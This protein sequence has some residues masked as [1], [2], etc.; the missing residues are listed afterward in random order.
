MHFPEEAGYYAGY[1]E[2]FVGGYAGGD[3]WIA[4]DGQQF[5]WHSWDSP[6]LFELPFDPV[7]FQAVNR[8]Q[9]DSA[10]LDRLGP[11]QPLFDMI[12]LF[13]PDWAGVDLLPRGE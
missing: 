13:R 8:L 2:A 10:A 4:R 9:G 11:L 6:L 7:R 12:R 1:S 3:V 5:W